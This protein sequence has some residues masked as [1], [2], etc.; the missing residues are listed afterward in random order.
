MCFG[1]ETGTLAGRKQSELHPVVQ[2][3]HLKGGVGETAAEVG[4]NDPDIICWADLW[5]FIKVQLDLLPRLP[6]HSCN[7]DIIPWLIIE[8]VG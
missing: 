2:I 4:G 7:D 8:L 1:S 6:A 5:R 3:I